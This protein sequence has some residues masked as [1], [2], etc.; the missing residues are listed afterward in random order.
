MIKKS[1]WIFIL[2]LATAIAYL[3]ADLATLYIQSKLESM[4]NKPTTLSKLDPVS[5]GNKVP[6]SHYNILK[7]R[8]LFQISHPVVDVTPIIVPDDPIPADIPL[9]SENP[10]AAYAGEFAF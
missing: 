1:W 2:I 6:S 5:K 3:S 10:A 4:F 7:T 9:Y 8:D